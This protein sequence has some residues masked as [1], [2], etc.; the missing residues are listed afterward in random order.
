MKKKILAFALLL[1]AI[2][3][4]GSGCVVREG[5]GHPHHYHHYRYN[6]YDHY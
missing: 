3:T 2:A 1:S 4:I 5:Y 6:H